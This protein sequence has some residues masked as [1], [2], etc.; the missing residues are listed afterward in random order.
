[1]EGFGQKSWKRIWE[2]IQRSRNTT[3][4][5][6]LIAMDIPMIGR[7][8]SR[9]LCR[10][11]NG[12]L[13]AFE[14]AVKSGFDFTKLNDFGDVLHRNIHEWFK[15]NENQ[16]L[17]E[18]LQEM[19]SIEKKGK[20]T[21]AQTTGSP[22]TGRIIVVTGKLL[23]FTRNSINDKIES[24]GAKAGS[25][26]SKSTDYLICGEKAGSKLNKARELGIQILTEEQFLSMAESA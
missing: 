14:A 22:F 9:E 19:V 24:L 8:A 17:W 25:A 13:S 21:A 11:F 1:M 10:Y 6:Y 18:D 23:H 16:Y 5:R 26:V 15:L 12:D 4:E 3:F 7:T 20:N 2:A